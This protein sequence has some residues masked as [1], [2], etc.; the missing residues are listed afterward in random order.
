MYIY[1]FCNEEII[2]MVIM[3][4]SIV[5]LGT[6]TVSVSRYVVAAI[7]SIKNVKYVLTPMGTIIE[8]DSVEKLFNIASKMHHAVL[9]ADVDRV[10]TSIK[11]DDRKDMKQSA[12]GKVQSVQK[13]L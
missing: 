9:D 10:V 7:K 1:H 12:S 13:K 6:E 3:E 2:V 4:I 11:I 8:A 5:P